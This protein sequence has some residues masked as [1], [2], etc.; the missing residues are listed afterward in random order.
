M[1]GKPWKLPKSVWTGSPYATLGR[2]IDKL[3]FLM[4]MKSSDKATA[5]TDWAADFMWDGR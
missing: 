5:A 2:E 1:L 4:W 3:I